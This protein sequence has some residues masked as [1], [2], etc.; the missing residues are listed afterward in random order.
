MFC[1]QPVRKKERDQGWHECHGSET[2]YEV[3]ANGK[4]LRLTLSGIGPS[5][6]WDPKEIT[7]VCTLTLDIRKR[8]KH[9]KKISK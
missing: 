4:S 3:K 1:K 2:L 8:L 5:G 7:E 9:L 6:D